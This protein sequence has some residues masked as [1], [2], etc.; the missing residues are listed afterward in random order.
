MHYFCHL[1]SCPF[2]RNHSF[3]RYIVV[4]IWQISTSQNLQSGK[5]VFIEK[6]MM[7]SY[8]FSSP[9]LHVLLSSTRMFLAARSLCTKLS[10]DSIPEAIWPQYPSQKVVL[11]IISKCS[12]SVQDFCPYTALVNFSETPSYPWKPPGNELH[13]TSMQLFCPLKVSL[14]L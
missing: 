2:N 10:M 1:K 13:F 4:T 6:C 5:A 7:I 14:K 9:S 11:G 8:I 3:M 12:L